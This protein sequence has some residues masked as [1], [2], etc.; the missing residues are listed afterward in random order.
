MLKIDE[1]KPSKIKGKK[2]VFKD[3]SKCNKYF[4]SR[5]VHISCDKIDV[6]TYLNSN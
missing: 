1:F 5:D 2:P 6:Q 3:V 4:E